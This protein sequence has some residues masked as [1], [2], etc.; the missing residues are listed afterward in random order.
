MFGWMI[1]CFGTEFF[2][3]VGIVE[4]EDNYYGNK[5]NDYGWLYDKKNKLMEYCSCKTAEIQLNKLQIGKVIYL[6]E[7]R[8]RWEGDSLIHIPFGYGCIY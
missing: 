7:K 8:E 4:Y 3:D 6:N 1:L 5:R 2:G